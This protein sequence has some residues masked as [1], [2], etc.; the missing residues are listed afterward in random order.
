ML[1]LE[2]I[3]RPIG[4]EGSEEIRAYLHI[5]CV[6]KLH[7]EYFVASSN[8]NRL[9]DALHKVNEEMDQMRVQLI[10]LQGPTS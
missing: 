2:L 9:Y 1:A 7:N 6:N 8:V 10:Q 4:V 5:P 3:F